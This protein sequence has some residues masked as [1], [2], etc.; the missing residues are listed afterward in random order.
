MKSINE[1]G[2]VL[3]IGGLI[4]AACTSMDLLLATPI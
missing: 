3:V 2:W 4:L 1:F